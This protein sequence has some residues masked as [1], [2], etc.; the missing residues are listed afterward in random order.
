M[1]C[2]TNSNPPHQQARFLL[3]RICFLGRSLRRT[4]RAER[5]R[6]VFCRSSVRADACVLKTALAGSREAQ[7]VA[8]SG[9]PCVTAVSLETEVLFRFPPQGPPDASGPGEPR[10]APESPGEP[11]RAPESPGEPRPSVASQLP[12]KRAN[13][14]NASTICAA[15]RSLERLS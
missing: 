14:V 7:R 13:G 12:A 8:A 10:R 4:V 11:R 15:V 9:P 1:V 5:G 6:R 2:F 3:S